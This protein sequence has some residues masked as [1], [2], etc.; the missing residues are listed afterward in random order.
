MVRIII[1]MWVANLLMPHARAQQTFPFKVRFVPVYEDRVIDLSDSA[2]VHGDLRIETLRFYIANPA[3]RDASEGQGKEITEAEKYHLVDAAVPSSGDILFQVPSGF[4][5][6]GVSFQ[7]GIDSITHSMGVLGGDLDP[8]LG[9]YWT[10][11]SG[12][13]HFKLEGSSPLSGSADHRFEIH[14]GGYQAAWPT[15]HSVFIPKRPDAEWVIYLDI[16]EGL[17]WTNLATEHHVMSPGKTASKLSRH[18]ITGF[19][20]RLR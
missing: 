10:W 16:S 18:F 14:L 1:A 2:F 12:Y 3:L 15:V 7:L 5:S 20:S 8:T 6:S 9:M 11:Q 19:R 4:V 13:I 17:L